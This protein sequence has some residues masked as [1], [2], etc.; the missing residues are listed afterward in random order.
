MSLWATILVPL[1]RG[2]G[3]KL[4]R[5][6]TNTKRLTSAEVTVNGEPPVS[7]SLVS[8]EEIPVSAD[9]HNSLGTTLFVWEKSDKKWNSFGN[10]YKQC[11]PEICFNNAGLV[12]K[13]RTHMLVSQL[14]NVTCFDM[15]IYVIR[16]QQS[17]VVSL[18]VLRKSPPGSD[19]GYSELW[20]P[21]DPCHAG[22]R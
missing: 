20:A 14:Q 17:S 22:S 9:C 5:L 4:H 2:G 10:N 12:V 11:V 13:F 1:R 8:R 6:Q 19:W 7:E 18:T 21:S 16:K 15:V 3:S